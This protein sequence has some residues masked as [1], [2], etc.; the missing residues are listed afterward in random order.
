MRQQY[1]CMCTRFFFNYYKTN[2]VLFVGYIL[3]LSEFYT[4]AQNVEFKENA[5]F[6]IR[7]KINKQHTHTHRLSSG[8]R[9]R[10]FLSYLRN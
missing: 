3:I 5:F 7:E 6:E 8:L 9:G 10:V 2:S 4:Q 1:D